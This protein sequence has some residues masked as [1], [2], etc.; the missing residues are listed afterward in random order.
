MQDLVLLVILCVF[1]GVVWG[2]AAFI[3]LFILSHSFVTI[4][5]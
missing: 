1:L 5:R 2:F 4:K 3:V